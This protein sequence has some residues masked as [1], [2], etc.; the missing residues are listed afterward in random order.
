METLTRDEL[1]VELAK[2]YGKRAK[3]LGL[4]F[5]EAY[6]KYVKRCEIRSYENLL[7]QFTIGNLA[8]PVKTKTKSRNDEYIIS[9][10]SED[11]CEDG[12]CKL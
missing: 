3:V 6:N 9:A 12:V 8:D 2:D 7:Q 11:D 4:K 1:I 5:E 10:P